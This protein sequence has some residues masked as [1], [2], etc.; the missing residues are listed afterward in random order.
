MALK[1]VLRVSGWDTAFSGLFILDDRY[2]ALFGWKIWDGWAS[3]GLSFQWSL[4]R[5]RW[6][7]AAPQGGQNQRARS[8]IDTHS[9]GKAS[10][11]RRR[12]AIRHFLQRLKTCP[13]F[14]LSTRATVIVTQREPIAR[15]WIARTK[16]R[17]YEPGRQVSGPSSRQ[18]IPVQ[19]WK[20]R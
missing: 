9:L 5:W 20:D 7:W 1:Y 16:C 10:L 19:A 15:S 13:Y 8:I 6:W 12:S 4:W 14:I 18:S 3:K 17:G 2:F 11:H